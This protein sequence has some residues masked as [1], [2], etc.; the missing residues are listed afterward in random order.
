MAPAPVAK[1]KKPK[2]PSN[3][4]ENAGS[5]VRRMSFGLLGRDK[6]DS[7]SGKG[8]RRSLVRAL[9]IGEGTE[10]PK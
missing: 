3:P 7:T 4:S 2:K 10:T 8:I 6:D 5:T 1:K 9:G